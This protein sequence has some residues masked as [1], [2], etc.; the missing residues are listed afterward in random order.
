MYLLYILQ[1]LIIKILKL[2]DNIT[3]QELDITKYK[4]TNNYYTLDL[5]Y[6]KVISEEDKLLKQKQIESLKNSIARREKLLSNEG[7]LN[8]APKELVLSEKEKLEQEKTL[9]LKLEA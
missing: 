8:K 1:Q 2:D 5:Y 6:E 9:L 7:Y 4:V 3:D